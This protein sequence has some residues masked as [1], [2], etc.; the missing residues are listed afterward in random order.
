M[1]SG[2]PGVEKAEKKGVVFSSND[3]AARS[4]P[5]IISTDQQQN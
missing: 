5:C 2:R 3:V 4:L 1:L